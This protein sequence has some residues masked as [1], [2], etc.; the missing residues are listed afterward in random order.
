MAKT[1]KQGAKK[2]EGGKCPSCGRP[3]VRRYRPFCS[4]RCAYLDLGRWLDG[5]YRIA[6][7]EPA[8]FDS[9]PGEGEDC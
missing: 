3:T 7:D 1:V 5:S 9:E 2:A 4:E 6:G 8:D